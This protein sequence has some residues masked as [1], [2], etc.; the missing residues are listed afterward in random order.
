LRVVVNQGNKEGNGV[1]RKGGGEEGESG[2][3]VKV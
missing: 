3:G 1:W 2:N